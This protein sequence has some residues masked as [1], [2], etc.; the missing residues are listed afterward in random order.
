MYSTTLRLDEDLTRFLQ[1]EARSREMSV[2]ALLAE[3]VRQAQAARARR[4]LARDW[5]AYAQ[6]AEAQDVAY[7]LPAQA[8]AAA[9]PKTKPYRAPKSPKKRA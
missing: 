1:E 9:E 3:L 8:D 5:A 6:D 2:N 7:A 4:H